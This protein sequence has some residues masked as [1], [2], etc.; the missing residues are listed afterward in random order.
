V[1]VRVPSRELSEL[2]RAEIAV[3]LRKNTGEFDD[4]KLLEWFEAD[5][6]MDWGFGKSELE[7][8]G[9]EF[10]ESEDTP[11]KIDRAAE[12]LKKWKVKL[13]DLWVL[14]KHRLICGDCTDVTV[15][16][17]LMGGG[18]AR[19]YLSD[20]PYG[21]SYADKNAYLNTVAKGNS[22]QTPIENDHLNTVEIQELWFESFS[23]A[24]EICED[25]APYYVCS[26]QG[27]ELAMMM[28]MMR[29]AGWLLKPNIIWVKNN[30]V[31]GRSDYQLK[32]EPILYGWKEGS[33]WFYGDR[34]CFSVWN[35]DK[36]VK[37]EYHP[38]TKPVEL[39]EIAITNSSKEGDIVFDG[40][41]GSG[42]TLI[43]CEN[44][45]RQ[46]RAIELSPA[47]VAVTLERYYEH[48]GVLPKRVSHG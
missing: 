24:I 22:V 13:G 33:H 36:P 30:H 5:D 19:L 46:C 1:D 32:H 48:T 8:I 12:L 39:F 42:T 35:V 10:E 21:V 14:G 20:P 45:Q 28:M 40:F 37:S 44:L 7:K 17:Q 29:K 31:L 16:A 27:G 4:K 47:Y 6:L 9:F 23:R 34:S 38:T 26:P 43:A 15:V 41:L 11:P 18:M 2:E 25:G 3:R